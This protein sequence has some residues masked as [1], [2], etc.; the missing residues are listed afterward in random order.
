MSQQ[1]ELFLFMVFFKATKI[2]PLNKNLV[3]KSHPLSKQ[4]LCLFK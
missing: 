3:W 4:V 1:V 2:K